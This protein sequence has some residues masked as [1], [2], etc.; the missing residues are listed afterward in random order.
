MWLL[1]KRAYVRGGASE[2]VAGCEYVR[3]RSGLVVGWSEVES[4][5]ADKAEIKAVGM[6]SGRRG[7]NEI[8]GEGGARGSRSYR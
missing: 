7:S 5:A 1:A 2:E 8:K 3:W 6:R 4:G